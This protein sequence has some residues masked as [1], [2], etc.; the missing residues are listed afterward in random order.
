MAGHLSASIATYGEK[1]ATTTI[2]CA[3]IISKESPVYAVVRL[4]SA[5]LLANA[6]RIFVQH[7]RNLRRSEERR[8]AAQRNSRKAE[9][10]INR[11][12]NSLRL[13]PLQIQ[14]KR[15]I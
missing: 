7:A 6:A 13:A 4:L 8:H 1:L 3:S 11:C 15:Y 9:S 14:H 10:H 12:R 5:L 2:M